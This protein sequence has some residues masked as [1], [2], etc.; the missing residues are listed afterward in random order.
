MLNSLY[1]SYYVLV[2]KKDSLYIIADITVIE[3]GQRVFKQ[4]NPRRY[5]MKL[6]DIIEYKQFNEKLT[7]EQQIYNKITSKETL[8]E[9]E[10]KILD[11]LI[12]LPML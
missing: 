10:E 9:S 1:L 8:H 7:K 12:M 3:L 6:P 5:N 11:E 2:N 4:H